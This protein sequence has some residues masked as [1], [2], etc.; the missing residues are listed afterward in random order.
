MGTWKED[1]IQALK[2]LNGCGHL[3]EINKEIKKIRKENLNPTFDRTVQRELETNSSGSEAYLG[4]EDIFYSILGK[5][6]GVWGLRS[7]QNRFYWVSQNRTFR[8]ERKEGYLWAPYLNKKRKELFHWNTLKKLKK[9]DI[10]FSHYKGTIPCVSIVKNKAAEHFSRPKEFSR[11]LPWMDD[12]R[13]VDTDYIDI[14]PIKLTK[15]VIKNLSKFKPDKNWIFDANYKHNIVYLLP[16]PLLA[17]KYLLDLIK[18]RQKLTIE[19]FENFDE[20]KPDALSLEDIKLKSRK[21]K[22]HGFRLSSQ[23]RKAIENYAMN[24]VIKK[25]EKENWKIYDVSTRKDK[26]Y[27]L[28]LTKGEKRLLCEVKGTS[29]SG[30]KVIVTKNE[31]LV[32]EKNYPNSILCIVSGICLDRSKKPPAASLG[33]LTELNPWKIENNKLEPLSYFYHVKD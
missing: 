20:D 9:G 6:K 21:D 2:N 16:L 5:G 26:G 12:G 32:A 17:A 31:V 14:E 27:D 8:V 25:Y 29:R 10:I 30:N 13:K 28:Y 19:D 22:T 33:K 1:T 4:G 11:S 7:Y 3:S 15:E 18:L 23:E 24:F